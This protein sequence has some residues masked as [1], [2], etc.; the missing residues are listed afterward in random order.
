MKRSQAGGQA[1][2]IGGQAA[3]ILIMIMAVVGAVSAGVASRSVENL[4]TQEIENTSSQSFKAAEAALEVALNT[5]ADVPSTELP[6]GIGTYSATY[7]SAGSDGFVSDAVEEGDV[8]QIFLSGAAGIT[9]LNLYWNTNSAVM[10]SILSGNAVNGYA[11][12]YYTA[13]P[14]TGRAVTNSFETTVDSP[15]T[16]TEGSYSFKTVSFDNKLTV[17]INLAAAKPPILVRVKVFYAKSSVGIEPVGGILASGQTVSINAV[18]TVA[19][20]VVTNLTF[21]KSSDRVPV[22]FDNVLYTNGSLTQ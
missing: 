1:R 16:Y 15:I 22:I 13:D 9:D 11:V 3:L 19:D 10:V 2:R 12:T 4:R 18:G 20:N 5:K 8:V 21:S 7:A 17:P 6:G 14:D